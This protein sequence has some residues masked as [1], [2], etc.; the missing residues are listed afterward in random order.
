MLTLKMPTCHLLL[1]AEPFVS[2]DHVTPIVSVV[3][4]DLGFK[5]NQFLQIDAPFGAGGKVMEVERYPY[6]SME[7]RAQKWISCY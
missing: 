2:S 4:L 3:P 6:G 5:K 7:H 1:G